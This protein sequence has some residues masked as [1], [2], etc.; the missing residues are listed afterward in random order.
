MR[1]Y[2]EV[3]VDQDMD[4]VAQLPRAAPGSCWLTHALNASNIIV[5]HGQRDH[6]Q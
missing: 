5:A 2:R 4:A 1:V 3:I 6:R